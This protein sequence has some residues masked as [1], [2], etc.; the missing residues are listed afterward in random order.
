MADY[1]GRAG[2]GT[3]RKVQSRD[4]LTPAAARPATLPP[5]SL[6][7][8]TT[9]PITR[10]EA[11]YAMA[12]VLALNGIAVVQDGEKFVQAVPM[13]QRAMVTARPQAGPRRKTAGPQQSPVHRQL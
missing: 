4:N 11:L 7:L 2:V 9:C 10:K 13:V 5:S 3:Q 8:K 1:L 6:R 12:T